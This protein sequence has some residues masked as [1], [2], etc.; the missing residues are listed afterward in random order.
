VIT[1]R[2]SGSAGA[3]T[4][5]DANSPAFEICTHNLVYSCNSN[6]ICVGV[7]DY[8]TSCPKRRHPWLGARL[9]GGQKR[10]ATALQIVR[11]LP[12]VG[13]QAVFRKDTGRLVYTRIVER[14]NFN[15]DMILF[16]LA[17]TPKAAWTGLLGAAGRLG[18]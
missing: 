7:A 5:A 13:T 9:V 14:V 16:E 4:N 12:F 3:I 15:Y 8:E 17:I 18:G 2:A 11:P 10:V 1:R 6:F